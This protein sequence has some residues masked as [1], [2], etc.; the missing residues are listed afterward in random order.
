VRTYFCPCTG[1]HHFSNQ[2]PFS[3]NLVTY[4]PVYICIFCPDAASPQPLVAAGGA[5]PGRPMWPWSRLLPGTV[6]SSLASRPKVR[7]CNSKKAPG[8]KIEGL[9]TGFLLRQVHFLQCFG[10]GIRCFLEPG[11]K[12][13]RPG[14]RGE[15]RD[16][17]LSTHF[18]VLKFFGCGSRSRIRDRV[19]PWIRDPGMEKIGS[20]IQDKHPGSLTL[21]FYNQPISDPCNVLDFPAVPFLPL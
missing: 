13:S 19:Q 10:S 5:A 3:K 9:R 17:F 8:K 14:F 1:T 2:T 15:H 11:W 6:P 18:L 16:F 4:F 7:P 20:G 21:I 12:K